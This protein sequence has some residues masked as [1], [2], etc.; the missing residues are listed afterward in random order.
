[1]DRIKI[2]KFTKSDL[3]GTVRIAQGQEIR[4]I[5]TSCYLDVAATN[6][7]PVH[8]FESQLC[9]LGYLVLNEGK[10]LVLLGHGIPGHVY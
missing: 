3:Q 5:G 10:T 9:G 6:H 1:M 8:L 7:D 4:N 2:Q